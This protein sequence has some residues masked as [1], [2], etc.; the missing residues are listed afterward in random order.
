MLGEGWMGS[1]ARWTKAATC[2]THAC[3]HAVPT[4][5]CF[6]PWERGEAAWGVRRTDVGTYYSPS[7]E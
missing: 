5:G 2:P 7:T 3:A 6:P 4:R 1:V